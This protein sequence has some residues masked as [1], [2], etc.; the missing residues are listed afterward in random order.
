MILLRLFIA[1]LE[2][3][4]V[5]FGG[6]YAMIPLIREKALENGWLTD[7][8]LLNMIAVSESTPG[9]VAVNMATF[10]GSRQAGIAGAFFATLGALL[11]SF[12]IILAIAAVMRNLLKYRG[13]EAFL[14]GVRPCVVALILAASANLFLGTVLRLGGAG[15][16]AD[17]DWYALGILAVIAA[18]SLLYGRLTGKKPPPA[19]MILM[20]ALLGM[21]VYS[22]ADLLG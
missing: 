7:E 6:G 17:P 9:P 18:V 12:V 5:S 16:T 10:I 4:A 2:I 15:L 11:P 14:K 1:F 22:A 20:S 21:A 19:V 13:V 8:E 3:G